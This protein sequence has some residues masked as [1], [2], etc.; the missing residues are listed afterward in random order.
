MSF[1]LVSDLHCHTWSQFSRINAD[2]VNSRLHI[3][4]SELERAADTALARGIT[5]MVVAGDIFHIRGSIDPETLNPVQSKIM[6]ILDKGMSIDMI[7]GNH[8]LKGRETTE[9]GS[10]IQT[11]ARCFSF[12][13]NMGVHNE[14]TFINAGSHGIA[15]VPWCA[16]VTDLIEKITNLSATVGSLAT[17][18]LIIHR[19]IDGTLIGM[20]EHGL[21]VDDLEVFG[22]RNVFAGDYHN[23]KKLAP[24]VWS[25]GA[26]THQTWSDIETKA[27][28]IIV[29]DDGSVEEHDTQ[30]PMFV[31]VSGM[32]T[33]DALDAAK[34]NYVRFRGPAIT[35]DEADEIKELFEDAGAAGISI[36]S[37]RSTSSA[38][39][40]TAKQT[41]AMTVDQSVMA[42]VDSKPDLSLVVDANEIKRRCSA[43][44][45]T[46]RAVEDA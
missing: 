3:I 39:T 5:R 18:D 35:K 2:G 37:P 29:N 10:S 46:V 26:L 6:E 1:L 41:Q 7:P 24:T 14:P 12:N 38:R 30:A 42:Y 31:D 21:T 40:M 11:L 19:G 9:L 33:Q 25:I 34:G 20:P 32:S 45:D 8:D 28:F 17:C 13:A 22:F 43:I 27:G 36:Q 44:L 4:L 23:R 15:L 16:T